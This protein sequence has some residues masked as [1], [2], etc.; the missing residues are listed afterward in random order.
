MYCCR[1]SIV[2]TEMKNILYIHYLMPTYLHLC[3]SPC[4]QADPLETWGFPFSPCFPLTG[5]KTQVGEC[6]SW[7]SLYSP[8]CL[9]L[10]LLLRCTPAEGFEPDSHSGAGAGGGPLRWRWSSGGALSTG[11]LHSAS[12]CWRSAPPRLHCRWKG[13]TQPN[14]TDGNRHKTN[15][16]REANESKTVH[17]VWIKVMNMVVYCTF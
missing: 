16:L 10:P 2:I 12:Q 7:P 15:A 6:H 1:I 8:H 3:W 17:T 4:Q 11:W 5:Q 13:R 9:R 14:M